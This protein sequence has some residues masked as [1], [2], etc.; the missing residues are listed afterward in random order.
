ME[1]LSILIV[2]KYYFFLDLFFIF[3][4]ILYKVNIVF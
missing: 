3:S 2:K 1:K 4:I